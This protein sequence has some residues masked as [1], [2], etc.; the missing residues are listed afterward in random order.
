MDAYPQVVDFNSDGKKDLIAG[1]SSG[2]VWFFQNMGTDKE[3][4]LAEGV[5][6]KAGG[7]PIK[8]VDPEYKKDKDGLYR[9]VPNTTTHMGIYS[10]IHMGDW[11]GDGLKDLLI[12]QDGPG[13]D[14]N[15]VLYKNIGTAS[16][17]AFA[18]PKPIKIPEPHMSRPS[19]Y[20]YDWDGDGK[21]DLVCGTEMSAVYFF[22]NTGKDEPQFDKGQKIELQGDGFKEGYRCRIA[23]TDWNNDGK[24]DMLIGNFYSNTQPS[25]GNIW[26]FL[27]K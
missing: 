18:E 10:K 19:P 14:D 2:H 9:L 17:P 24:V 27:G 16:K 15:L 7:K 12:G 23:L 21:L 11:D 6:V 20:L 1:D 4:K 26:L 25:G 8:G 5:Q 3:P 22:R 13:G